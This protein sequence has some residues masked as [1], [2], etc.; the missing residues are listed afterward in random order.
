MYKRVPQEMV[1]RRIR[2]LGDE[3]R[4]NGTFTVLVCDHFHIMFATEHEIIRGFPSELMAVGYCHWLVR[5]SLHQFRK[6]GASREEVWERWM[7]FGEGAGVINS[8][9]KTN[10]DA[11]YCLDHPDPEG[12]VPAWEDISA[13][14][15][16][17]FEPKYDWFIRPDEVG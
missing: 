5:S 1:E 3:A 6:Q 17:D 10:D 13:S 4:K 14:F 12:P 11:R 16:A 7:M 15:G 2:E 8:A 9:Y